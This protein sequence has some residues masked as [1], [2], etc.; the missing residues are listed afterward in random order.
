MK[1]A[2][3]GGTGKLGLALAQRLH[4]SGYD[5]V[6]GSRHVPKAVEAARS[7][8]TRVVG[9]SNADAAAQC[10]IAVIAV[11]YTGHRALLDSVGDCLEGKI[12]D[13]TTVPIDPGNILQVKTESGRSAAEE[14]A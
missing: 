2:V 13:D 5:V 11:P 4:T 1:I 7:V 9:L 14:T 3:L 6:I 8:G 12:V 10:D